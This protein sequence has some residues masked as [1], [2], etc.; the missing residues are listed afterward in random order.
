MPKCSER[1]HT[2]ITSKKQMGLFGAELTRRRSGKKG[3]MPGI[4]DEE[5]SSHL[6]E[7]GG[8]NLPRSSRNRRAAAHA[9]KKGKPLEIKD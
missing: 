4:T 2:P 7:A 6:K 5:L 9:I 8:K 3:N 1:K